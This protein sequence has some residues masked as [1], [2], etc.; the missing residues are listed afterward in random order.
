[1]TGMSFRAGVSFTR[2]YKVVLKQSWSVRPSFAV[3]RQRIFAH[4]PLTSLDPSMA[5][6]QSSFSV[7]RAMA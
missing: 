4:P 3:V 1:M 6:M 2:R 5:V 7:H